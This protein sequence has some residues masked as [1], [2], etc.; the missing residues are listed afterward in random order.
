[1]LIILLTGS[2]EFE[3]EPGKYYA[4]IIQ[5]IG[6][7]DSIRLSLGNISWNLFKYFSFHYTFFHTENLP[8]GQIAHID[9]QEE[10]ISGI[11]IAEADT[12]MELSAP[13][14]IEYTMKPYTPIGIFVFPSPSSRI[15]SITI[16]TR[17]GVNRTI[18]L[19]E[20]DIEQFTVVPVIMNSGKWNF[21]RL[22]GEGNFKIMVGKILLLR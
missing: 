21:I 14:S 6:D 8:E 2:L 18:E 22:F 5:T 3:V 1:M 7:M 16:L 4:V 13:D 19:H 15:D 12:V 10:S 9:I 11:L 17:G 20:S